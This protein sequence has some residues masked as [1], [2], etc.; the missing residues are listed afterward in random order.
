MTA[1][2][3]A[4][5]AYFL[6][7]DFIREAFWG[8]WPLQFIL[9]A[10][11]RKLQ[12]GGRERHDVRHVLL[13]VVVGT[14]VGDVGKLQ[15]A[16]ADAPRAQRHHA[17]RAYATGLAVGS[18][19]QSRTAAVAQQPYALQRGQVDRR[20]QRAAVGID[21]DGIVVAGLKAAGGGAIA[22]SRLISERQ[23]GVA[24]ADHDAVA[25]DGVE[26]DVACGVGGVGRSLASGVGLGTFHG[27]LTTAGGERREHQ[28]EREG[29]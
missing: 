2:R 13:F 20:E 14:V 25:L 15:P 19:A 28:A 10:A 5:A 7:V 9:H 24:F 6:S 26:G 18:D 17:E 4:R 21:G 16:V 8:L 29:K 22:E 23:R 27:L 1:V 12:S 3:A 11:E